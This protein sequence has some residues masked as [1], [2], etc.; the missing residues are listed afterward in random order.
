MLYR[1]A[2]SVAAMRVEQF[3]F[4]HGVATFH[5]DPDGVYFDCSAAPLIFQRNG[6]PI[7]RTFPVATTDRQLLRYFVDEVGGL[8]AVVKV[9]GRSHGMGTM[10]VDSWPALYSLI[11]HLFSAGYAPLLTS[12]VA[13]AIHWRVIVV[14][15]DAVAAYRNV[16]S[17]DDFRTFGSE[18]A[19]DFTA[20]VPTRLAR[21]AVGAVEALRLEFGGVDILEHPTGRLYLLEANFPC[22]FAQPQVVAGID[23]A[24]AILVHLR[25]KAERLAG[26]DQSTQAY[27]GLAA[28]RST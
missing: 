3:L 16:Q 22:Y 11:D 8:P 4:A 17:E 5:R 10:R 7:P 27:H 9:L 26:S 12:Y 13:D 20:E 18:D 19:S 28:H 1:P 15:N 2:I 14:G 6:L 25:D 21:L 24:G 23:V